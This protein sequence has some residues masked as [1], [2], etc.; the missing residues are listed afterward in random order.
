MH[1]VAVCW[2]T[3]NCTRLLIC[4]HPLDEYIR[5]ESTTPLNGAINVMPTDPSI[6]TKVARWM[7][8]TWSSDN[9]RVHRDASDYF[10]VAY[11][12]VLLLG[13]QAYLIRNSA[14]EGR[15][16]L[17]DEVKHWVKR[18]ID[19]QSGRMC[20][21]KLLFYEKFTTRIGGIRFECFRSPRKEARIL[22]LVRHHVNF[23][24]GV[25]LADEKGNPVRILEPISGPTL[26]DRVQNIDQDHETYFQA[27]LPTILE[28]FIECVRAIHFL[29]DHGE[30][31]G[32]IR[33]DHILVDNHTGD[34]RWIDFDYNYRHRENIYGYDL[35]GLGNILAFI[36]GKGDVLL[37]ELKSHNPEALERLTEADLNVVFR[38][39][40]VNL[41]KIYP[42]IP[43]ALNHVLLHFGRGA[44]WFY[45]HTGQFLD[46]L[47]DAAATL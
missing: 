14:R 17:D 46:E 37:H 11:G 5:I 2:S 23:M 9:L 35:F 19:L 38:N 47:T 6:I 45:E 18:A 7:P 43:T 21:I 12:D 36:V 31:H 42:Y 29:H 32:D 27:T 40:V 22:E 8:K 44:H 1:V 33:R 3:S 10:D 41:Q 20:I 24:Q 15:F 16:G 13:S 30:K 25:T 39:R 34:F 4:I 28:G 26:A